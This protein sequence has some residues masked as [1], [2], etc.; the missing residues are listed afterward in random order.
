M[1]LKET[2]ELIIAIKEYYPHAKIE[3]A[4]KVAK[5][6]YKH[7]NRLDYQDVAN[8]L[9]VY[10]ESEDSEY[11]PT[12][13]KLKKLAEDGKDEI[14]SA[15]DA[16]DLVL[17]AL[18]GDWYDGWKD[19]PDSV[20]RVIKSPAD[21]KRLSMMNQETLITSYKNQFVREYSDKN[22]RKTPVGDYEPRVITEDMIDR[23]EFK[24]NEI[25]VK[26]GTYLTEYDWEWCNWYGGSKYV[27]E[28]K[29]QPINLG[30]NK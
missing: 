21:L 6:W 5:R 29:G 14:L 2:T 16:F 13:S 20:K 28:C 7:F 1:N 18:S 4:T 22:R 11:P 30:G 23:D 19:L 17:E 24:K 9:E 25:K 12:I 8:A 10:I 15:Y 27:K 3:D 26:N